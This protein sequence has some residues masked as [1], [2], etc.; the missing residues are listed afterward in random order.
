MSYLIP[1]AE[2]RIEEVRSIEEVARYTVLT[3]LAKKLG[4]MTAADIEALKAREGIAGVISELEKSL[5]VR[6]VL[7]KTDLGLAN[8][9]WKI[10]YTAAYTWEEKVRKTLKDSTCLSFFGATNLSATPKTLYVKFGL[11]GKDIGVWNFEKL[12][13]YVENVTGYTLAPLVILGGKTLVLQFYGNA[14]GDD[15]PVLRGFIAE[16]IGETV[17]P[18]AGK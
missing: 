2:L 6:E 4:V 5:V 1:V 12:Y 9:E 7:P 16:P 11:P 13:A 14:S 18:S 8:E 15:L 10:S 17:T 3:E